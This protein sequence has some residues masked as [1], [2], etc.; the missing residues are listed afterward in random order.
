MNDLVHLAK[1]TEKLVKLC[2]NYK[3]WDSMHQ[4]MSKM[5]EEEIKPAREI[6]K[7]EMID[8]KAFIED[9]KAAMKK[10]F[11][12]NMVLVTK[13]ADRNSKLIEVQDN[14]LC[15][16]EERNIEDPINS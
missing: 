2:D 12:G 6:V 5:L 16:F 11:E 8:L 13:L 7:Q 1:E 4:R 14:R 10:A 3:D 9:V 15:D